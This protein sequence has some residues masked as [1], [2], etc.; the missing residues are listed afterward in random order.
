NIPKRAIIH[1]CDT[2]LPLE[3]FLLT[4]IPINERKNWYIICKS[5][6]QTMCSYGRKKPK[7]VS[8]NV[9]H[10]GGE[11]IAMKVIQSGFYQPI[12]FKDV[13]SFMAKSDQCIQTFLGGRN[14][15]KKH[16]S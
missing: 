13:N 14:A 6:T 16:S 3:L 10:Y 8:L 15:P 7:P 12:P 2:K 1:C 5:S 11:R 9:I 4:S